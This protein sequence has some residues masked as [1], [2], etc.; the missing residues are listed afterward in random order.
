MDTPS[1]TDTA[2]EAKSAPT[3]GS[4]KPDMPASANAAARGTAAHDADGSLKVRIGKYTATVTDAV[5]LA[6]IPTS[7]FC[8]AAA[9]Q[10]GYFSYY[11]VPYRFVSFDWNAVLSCIVAL[12]SS[13]SIAFIPFVLTILAW[14]NIRDGE[15][16]KF[17]FL[18]YLLLIGDIS[19]YRSWSLTAIVLLNLAFFTIMNIFLSRWHK[20]NIVHESIPKQQMFLVHDII[21]VGIGKRGFITM[22]AFVY[23]VLLFFDAGWNSAS[24]EKYYWVIRGNPDY[25]LLSSSASNI[26]L[27]PIVP[28]DKAFCASAPPCFRRLAEYRMIT[29]RGSDFTYY[30]KQLGKLTVHGADPWKGSPSWLR[31][32]FSVIFRQN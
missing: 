19:L 29:Q 26:L 21:T 13:L 16:Y 4:D 15:F 24:N 27:S 5:L 31:V 23:C 17:R 1:S 11:E 22:L 6:I 25:V 10:L 18:F 7:L 28:A 12:P 14:R 30:R 3:N 9:F 20:R 2:V 32:M 8:I